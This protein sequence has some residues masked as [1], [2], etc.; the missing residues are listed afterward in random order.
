[1]RQLEGKRILITGASSGIGAA[2]MQLF[3][4]EGAMVIGAARRHDE[5]ELIAE[6]IRQSGGDARF[7]RTDIADGDSVRALFT[8]IESSLGGLDGA[9]N[10]AS[11]TQASS[12]F[13]QT[14][15]E[16]YDRLFDINVRGT[17]LCMKAELRLM[18]A[19][20]AGAIVNT[21][22]IAGMR[23][24]NEISVYSAT[25]H[26][27]IGLTRS[28][29]IDA[30]PFGVRVNCICPGTTRTP[31]MEEQMRT[32]EGGMALTISRIPLGRISEPVEQAQAALWLLSDQA[33][34]VTGQSFA[35]DGGGTIR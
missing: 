4:A 5:G 19:N 21:S 17:W 28:A 12:P 30:A 26:A 18:K 1:M 35:V 9:F 27:V 29:A 15:D 20:R 25:K 14:P 24:F 10:N 2:A 31:M 34:F 32:R 13:E 11:L 16:V 23:G 3:A 7:I 22:S 6:R 33:S 8:D